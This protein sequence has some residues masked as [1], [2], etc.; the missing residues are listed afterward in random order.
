MKRYP[1]LD[2][3]RGL[4]AL[5]VVLHHAV[6][7]IP[8][9]QLHR[10]V[11]LATDWLRA[12][13]YAV[14]AFI[15]LSGYSLMLPVA[16]TGALKGGFFGYLKRRSIR[17]LP[18]YYAALACFLALIA[19]IPSLRQQGLNKRWNLALPAFETKVIL[20]HLFMVFNLSSD[21][22]LRI[23]P[24]MWSVA[25]E[26]QIYL[27]F[28]LLIMAWR[29]WG[30]IASISLAFGI[31]YGLSFL[32]NASSWTV[33]NPWYAGL[34]A[35]GMLAASQGSRHEGRRGIV[36]PWVHL[37]LVVLVFIVFTR[38][39]SSVILF[40]VLVAAFLAHRASIAESGDQVSPL[41][42]VLESPIA[43][44]LGAFSY[45]IYLVHFPFLSLAHNLM[46]ARGMNGHV[47]L[48]ILVMVVSPLVL[49]LSYLFH[50]AF[51]RPFLPGHPKS[52]NPSVLAAV[53][54]PAPQTVQ[55]DVAPR[56]RMTPHFGGYVRR[57][58]IDR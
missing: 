22:S 48:A 8:I 36:N 14:C 18:T 12:G 4:A 29:R 40:G 19:L 3:L 24:P 38:A 16:E 35:I 27:L 34:F 57:P 25:M 51:E 9:D 28:P 21:L 5:F 44:K 50:L 20:T 41:F 39:V 52:L 54:S 42:R 49:G 58:R 45:S 37:A 26:W 56:P 30:H 7:E 47:K 31:A 17:I 43:L 6:M 10:R 53:G 32:M 23:D 55:L 2:G 46:I 13:D 33:M 11:V 1:W 15:V